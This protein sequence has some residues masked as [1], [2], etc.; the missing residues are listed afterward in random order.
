MSGRS[1][2]VVAFE[3]E[4][5]DELIPRACERLALPHR[6]SERLVHDTESVPA[7]SAVQD[8]P[9]MASPGE[10]TEYQLIV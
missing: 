8:W 10:I 3:G 9:G 6:G 4:L 7:L 2:C 1:T 5:A